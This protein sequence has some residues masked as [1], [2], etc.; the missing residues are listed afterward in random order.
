MLDIDIMEALTISIEEKIF[1]DWRHQ[2]FIDSFTSSYI[3]MEI[4]G[5]EYVLV[6]HEVQDGHYFSEFTK[7]VLKDG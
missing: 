6:L 7:E 5:K 1:K 3:N 2:G 4:D